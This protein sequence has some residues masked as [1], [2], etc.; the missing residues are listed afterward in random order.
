MK[1]SLM[2]QERLYEMSLIRPSTYPSVVYDAGIRGKE[3]KR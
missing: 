2:P 1:G 3:L